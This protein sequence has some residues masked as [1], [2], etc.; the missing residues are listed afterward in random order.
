M[1]VEVG[2]RPPLCRSAKRAAC[3]PGAQMRAGTDRRQS[4]DHAGGTAVL[5][6]GMMRD[7]VSTGSGAADGRCFQR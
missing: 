6:Y 3:F 5:R 7:L 4:L 1:V 2:E